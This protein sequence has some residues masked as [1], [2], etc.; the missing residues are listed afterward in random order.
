MFSQVFVCS[1][2]GYHWGVTGRPPPRD[3]EPGN[4]VNM[5]AVRILLECNLVLFNFAADDVYLLKNSRCLYWNFKM[6]IAVK[7]NKTSEYSSRMRTA[8]A[9]TVFPGGEGVL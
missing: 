4:T 3:R 5:R 9:L 8:R 6:K 1:Q 2:W 7:L